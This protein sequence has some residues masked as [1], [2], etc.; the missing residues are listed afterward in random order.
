MSPSRDG[1]DEDERVFPAAAAAPDGPLWFLADRDAFVRRFVL[2][3]VL[4]PPPGMRS[5]RPRG[6]GR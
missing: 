4:A 5:V 2:T 6:I 1:G 3:Q